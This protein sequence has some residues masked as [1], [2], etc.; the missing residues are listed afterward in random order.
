MKL[1]VD[2]LGSLL[3]MGEALKDVIQDIIIIISNDLN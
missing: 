2:I 3:R 1:H